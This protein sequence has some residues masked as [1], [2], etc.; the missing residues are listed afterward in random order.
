MR[1]D[2]IQSGILSMHVSK[3]SPSAETRK[4]QE[5]RQGHRCLWARGQDVSVA[6]AV[7]CCLW[8]LRSQTGEDLEKE[9]KCLTKER[10]D[11]LKVP[12]YLSDSAKSSNRSF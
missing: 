4:M 2:R 12:P 3:R 7:C 9:A 5:D 11:Q 6:L 1:K 8:A 10:A